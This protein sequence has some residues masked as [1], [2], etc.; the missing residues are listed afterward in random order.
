MES[1]HILHLQDW[2]TYLSRWHRRINHLDNMQIILCHV[3]RINKPTLP[4]SSSCDFG[5]RQCFDGGFHVIRMKKRKNLWTKN[6]HSY[7]VW[8]G[9]LDVFWFVTIR[10]VLHQAGIKSFSCCHFMLGRHGSIWFRWF[11]YLVFVWI[12]PCCRASSLKCEWANQRVRSRNIHELACYYFNC[13][14]DSQLWA[15]SVLQTRLLLF[16]QY[17]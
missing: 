13:S 8:V 14:Q 3:H 4:I 6:L 1:H 9:R 5:S 11:C 12:A 16:I 2:V 17:S 10:F 15:Q 7:T